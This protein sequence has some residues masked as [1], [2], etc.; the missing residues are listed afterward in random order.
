MFG[1]IQSCVFQSIFYEGL[2]GQCLK[3]CTGFG[4]Q[5]KD[6][7]CYV[8]TIQNCCC[9]IR[10]YIADEF[11]FHL[12]GI[13]FLCPVFQCQIHC[14][15]SE[16]TAAD[17]DLNNGC[18]FLTCCICDL[19][20][21]YFVCKIC[22]LLLLFFIESTFV[23]AVSVY[24]LTELTACQVMKNHSLLSGVNNFTIVKCFEFF[25]QLCFICQFLQIFQQFVIYLLCSIIIRKAFC[26]RCA[27]FLYT[28]STFLVLRLD[29]FSL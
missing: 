27:V 20:G 8:D 17:T 24:S 16:V 9:I 7:M 18:K 21:M 1:S 26:H 3:C 11:C 5:D 22:D 29:F 2:V 14:T 19:S 10:V 28:F 4:N 13:V 12:E 25:S 23:C 15:R 6:R